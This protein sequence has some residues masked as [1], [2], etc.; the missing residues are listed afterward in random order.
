[1]AVRPLALIGL[2]ATPAFADY[3]PSQYPAYET[4]ALCHGL[5]GVSHTDKFPNLAGQPQAYIEA[6][7][8]NFLEGH[9]TNDGGQMVSIVTELQPEDIPFVANW[10]STQDPPEP[11]PAEMTDAGAGQFAE[12]GCGGCHLGGGDPIV[13]YLTAQKPGYLA[14]QMTDFRED[15]R[16]AAAAP[17][18][19]KDLL[20]ISDAQIEAIAAYLGATPR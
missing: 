7:I 9:R 14:K 4:C 18:M 5:F 1:M 10:F 6:Q 3:D 15:R 17:G 8:V 20:N 12:L 19:H 16:D 13:P 11:Y 2:L